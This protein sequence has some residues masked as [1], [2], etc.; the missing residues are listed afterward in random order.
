MSDFEIK[1]ED[2]LLL[3]RIRTPD[4]TVLTSYTVHDYKAHIDANGLEYMVDGG[5][6]YLRRNTHTGD[7]AYEELSVYMTEDHELNRNAFHWGTYGKHGDQPLTY[8]ELSELTTGHIV[9]II[10]T[11]SRMGEYV[12]RL[13][14]SE[15]A[16]RIEHN[17]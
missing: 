2:R 3:N 17:L 1:D 8:R 6:S 12:R 5:T 16:Y 13:M 14:N 4:G 15:L 11:Q 9:A 10:E 7:N